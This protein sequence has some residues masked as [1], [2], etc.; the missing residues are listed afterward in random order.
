[1]PIK[2][3][4]GKTYGTLLHLVP[5][6]IN[7]KVFRVIDDKEPALAKKRR[8]M[9]GENKY[10]FVVLYNSRNIQRKRTSNVILAYRAFC[11]SLAP[12]QSK[13]C[14]LFLHT[15]PRHDAGTDLPAVKEALCP[16]YD[17]AFSPGKIA[18]D[19]MAYLY[20][21]ADVTVNASSNEGFGLS[22]AESLMCGTPVIV[23]VTGGLQDQIGQVDEEGNPVKF[24]LNFGSNNVGKYRSHGVWAYPVYPA[25]RMIQGSIPTPY[26]F[27]DICKWEDITDGLTYWYLMTREQ[28]KA[29]GLKGR[30]WCLGEGGLNA[31]NMCHQFI[32]AMDYTMNH[33]VPVKRFDVFTSEDFVGHQMP[34][35]CPGFEM[36][37]PNSEQLRKR[38]ESMLTKAGLYAAEQQPNDNDK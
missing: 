31:D 38:M 9:F 15:E 24:S 3:P 26:I 27:D 18:P 37:K 19:E 11:D 17:V 10:N 4:N 35:N 33:F 36:Y 34:N 29:C 30:E 12:E 21:M 1:M 6:G 13:K 14:L 32:T 16:D 8:D 28:R 20:N 2:A 25:T 23:N 7:S 22:V 5:H